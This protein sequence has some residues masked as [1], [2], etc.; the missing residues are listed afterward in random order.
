MKAY[1][2]YAPLAAAFCMLSFV[3]CSGSPTRLTPAAPFAALEQSHAAPPAAAKL[4]QDLFI[5]ND[6]G[7]KNQVVAFLAPDGK[8]VDVGT[9]LYGSDDW[10]PGYPVVDSKGNLFIPYD[11]QVTT[12]C[13]S[14]K[15][16]CIEEFAP[17]YDGKPFATITRGVCRPASG[18]FSGIA[19][20][21][22]DDLFVLNVCVES[23]KELGSYIQEF[24]PPYTGAS[25]AT[26]R[27]PNTYSPYN[28]LVS[29]KSGNI[30]IAAFVPGSNSSSEVLVFST[31]AKKWGQK[32]ASITTDLGKCN[33][34]YCFVGGMALDSSDDLFIS[35]DGTSSFVNEL[36]PPY[37]HAP[38]ATITLGVQDAGS[39]ALDAKNDLF[40]ANSKGLQSERPY[41]AEYV[42]PYKSKPIRT[43]SQDIYYIDDITQLLIGNAANL[44]VTEKQAYAGSAGYSLEFA[45][46]YNAKPLI[47][48]QEPQF[49][50]VGMALGPAK[51][52]SG[53]WML[54]DAK[55]IP[56]LIYLSNSDTG[57]VDVYNY[58]THA[59]VGAFSVGDPGNQCVDASGDVFITSGA[60]VE[61]YAHGGKKPLQ[62]L[63]TSDAAIGCSIAPGGDLA[64]ANA[65][66][67]FSSGNPAVIDV[68]PHAAGSP[69]IIS[70]GECYYIA[71][72]AYD[73]KG[74]L[75][76][77]GTAR[78]GSETVVCELP[79]GSSSVRLVKSNVAEA[80]PGVVMW[81]GKYITLYDNDAVGSPDE[82]AIYQMR[83][84]AAGN[85]TKV[86]ETLIRDGDCRYGPNSAQPFIVGNKNPPVNNEQGTA[87][88]GTTYNCFDRFDYWSYPAGG[89][90]TSFFKFD[91]SRPSGESV[92]IAE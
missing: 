34:V 73:G 61:E 4:T 26:L 75:Y 57:N 72:I 3:A 70:A 27:F 79:K 5:T 86:G 71:G 90:P 84:N 64:V 19:L 66:K 77:Q 13:S 22:A 83:E 67:S 54:P 87:V 25:I 69:K 12:P 40:V 10:E 7:I 68:Y 65:P 92:S 91:S 30:F 51:S 52:A 14:T 11:P 15:R 60:A 76:L 88:I 8:R 24:K 46:P 9:S 47:W 31:P 74:N 16:G 45:P 82:P 56:K 43:I 17:P 55:A 21:A 85:L 6:S 1:W 50:P 48:D 38:K 18:P 58:A 23:S 80:S 63:Q 28:I 37:T 36:S 42:A 2:S 53:T 62:T 59:A 89:V 41:I 32:I 20:N 44:F 81:D 29:Q 49:S 35:Y 78:Q 33:G 39:L